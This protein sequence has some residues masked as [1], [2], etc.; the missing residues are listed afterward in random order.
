MPP[1]PFSGAKLALLFNDHLLTYKR[2]IK[3]TIPFPGCWD[4]AGGGREGDE[5]PVECAL[6]ELEEEFALRLS[7]ERIEWRRS[8]P[9]VS[10]P[11]W[12]AWFL[13]GQLT[14]AEID[15]IAFG[16]EGQYWQMM[17]IDE[18]LEHAEGVW[19]LQ[20]RLRDYLAHVAQR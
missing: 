5:T 16:D 20:A 4:F 2:D 6:R 10:H 8:Y 17:P 13:V 14:Q 7:P 15:A 1:K 19:Y 18:Y 9:S 11:G 3:D 12:E